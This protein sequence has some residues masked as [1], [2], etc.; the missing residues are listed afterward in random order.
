MNSQ[1]KSSIQL[2]AFLV[3]VAS[4]VTGV[5]NVVAAKPG[6]RKYRDRLPKVSAPPTVPLPSGKRLRI[7]A[8]VRRSAPILIGAAS[9]AAYWGTESETILNREFGFVTPGN[10]F[11][12]SAIHPEPDV[13]RW[14]KADD[15]IRRCE[16]N[17]QVIRLHGPISPQCSKWT[18]EDDRTAKELEHNLREF[19]TELCKRYN[20][21]QCVRWMDVVNETVTRE[22]EWFGPKPGTEKWENPWTKIGFDE[23][24]PLRPPLYIKQAFEITNRHAPRIKQLINQHGDMEQAMWRKVAATVV[25]LRKAGLRVDGIGW[26]AHVDA[27]FE[28]ETDNIKNLHAMISWAH[29][30]DLEFHVTENT[31]WLKGDMAGNY[32]AQAATY[33][34][35]LQTLVEHSDTGIVTWNAWQIRDTETQNPD[36]EG[37]LFDAQGNA[38]PAYFAIQKQ[39]AKLAKQ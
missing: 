10:D 7:L 24:D 3:I 12:Q 16:E 4:F 34:A 20:K 28:K 15:W 39:L 1:P 13:W 5:Q 35:I 9:N 22:G 8:P 36:R 31:V 18:V 6:K 32:E 27:G 38:K 33:Q 37:C 30:N 14:A 11:K 21:K 26:Q 29:R 23:S 25:Y 19:M 17:D 2:L